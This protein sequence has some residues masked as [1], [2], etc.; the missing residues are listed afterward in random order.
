MSE[1]TGH[2]TAAALNILVSEMENCLVR[3]QAQRSLISW[4]REALHPGS[5]LSLYRATS[6]A[7]SLRQALCLL[8]AASATGESSLAVSAVTIL[9][10]AVINIGLT[11]WESYQRSVEM[12]RRAGT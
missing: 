1:A 8:A 9:L 2:T 12:Y 11:C 3:C 7:F 5:Q 4:L 10:L 6:A